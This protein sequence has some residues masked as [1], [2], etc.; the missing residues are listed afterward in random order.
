MYVCTYMIHECSYTFLNMEIFTSILF[1]ISFSHIVSHFHI[2]FI[3]FV[4]YDI[5]YIIRVIYFANNLVD[6]THTHTHMYHMI[7]II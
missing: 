5:S 1:F 7:Y 4:I 2:A 6:D 3:R